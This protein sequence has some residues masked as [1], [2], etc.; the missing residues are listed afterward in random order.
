MNKRSCLSS[1][2]IIFLQLTVQLGIDNPKIKVLKL[3][4]ITA[5][6]E[7]AQQLVTLPYLNRPK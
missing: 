5:A 4:G 7:Y 6:T 1:V 3:R 2:V